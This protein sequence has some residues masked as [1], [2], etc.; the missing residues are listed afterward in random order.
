MPCF[1]GKKNDLLLQP[2]L[3]VVPSHRTD[4]LAALFTRR[5]PILHRVIGKRA[6]LIRIP[7]ILAAIRT[8]HDLLR[9]VLGAAA[10]RRDAE[11]ARQVAGLKD[12]ARTAALR[13]AFLADAEGARGVLGVTL[14]ERDLGRVAVPGAFT[15][16]VVLEAAAGGPETGEVIAEWLAAV[17][18]IFGLV[19]DHAFDADGLQAVDGGCGRGLGVAVWEELAGGFVAAVGTGCDFGGSG[20]TGV[21]RVGCSVGVGGGWGCCS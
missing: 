17:G 21:E 14:R 7:R 3:P 6:V 10:A 1:V 4:P 13:L 20:A 15:E 5:K 11:I 12:D 19:G 16:A 9:A 8:S 2:Q 18:V